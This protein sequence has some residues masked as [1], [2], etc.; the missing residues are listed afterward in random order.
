MGGTRAS[1]TIMLHG[2][3][4]KS[5]VP[6]PNA[7]CLAC[8]ISKD[9]EAGAKTEEEDEN[10]GEGGKGCLDHAEYVSLTP[11]HHLHNLSVADGVLRTICRR[12]MA[13]IWRD[14]RCGRDMVEGLFQCAEK[15]GL[16]WMT[17]AFWNPN[18]SLNKGE[19]SKAVY[20]AR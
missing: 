20:A 11:S 5:S 7:M 6:W 16:G 17:W 4:V 18:A 10:G 3:N 15:E 13:G 9:E 1:E 2:V 8:S 19:S 12:Y 14:R